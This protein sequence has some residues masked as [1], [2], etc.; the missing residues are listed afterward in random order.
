LSAFIGRTSSY[1]ADSKVTGQTEYN[2]AIGGQVSTSTTYDYLDAPGTNNNAGPLAVTTL[3]QVSTN[4]N[5]ANTIINSYYNYDWWDSGKELDI[6]AQ[7]FNPQVHN[8]LSGFSHFEYDVNGNLK[9]VDDVMAGRAIR[10]VTDA[11]GLILVRDEISGGSANAQGVVTNAG[12]IDKHHEFY[13]FDGKRIGDLWNEH[14]F[15]VRLKSGNHEVLLKAPAGEGK[16]RATEHLLPVEIGEGELT[17]LKLEYA[18][19]GDEPGFKLA[20]VGKEGKKE[21]REACELVYSKKL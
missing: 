20:R 19:E 6:T 16:R 1:D 7:P 4:P 13:Y 5:L 12:T 10:F 21:I 11:E 9:Q 14:Y 3:T 18:P 17:Y 15:E 2:G 8:W